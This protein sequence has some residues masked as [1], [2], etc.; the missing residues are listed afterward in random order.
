[1]PTSREVLDGN[2][3]RFHCTTSGCTYSNRD[4]CG[5]VL[6]MRTHF[7]YETAE[8][9]M[10]NATFIFK[11]GI[12]QCFNCNRK[13][14]SQL[15]FRE[16][17]RHHILPFP[18]RCHCGTTVASIPDLRRHS[19]SA[20]PKTPLQM[21]FE[22]AEQLLDNIFSEIGPLKRT[23]WFPQRIA[24]DSSSEVEN[25]L[26][27]N[28]AN[29]CSSVLN[30][31]N[32]TDIEMAE[33]A[34]SRISVLKA[35]AEPRQKENCCKTPSTN[36]SKSIE[37]PSSTSASV[38]EFS[39]EYN[40]INA[41]SY[42]TT[43]KEPD[44]SGFCV[45]NVPDYGIDESRID[46]IKDI[47]Q[48]NLN[49][50][51]S[52]PIKWQ[53]LPQSKPVS[54]V[55]SFKSSLTVRKN[56]DSRNRKRNNTPSNSSCLLISKD[57]GE[58][59]V[60]SVPQNVDSRHTARD[61]TPSISS[62]SLI[63]KDN[64]QMLGE[65][66]SEL[67]TVFSRVTE[68]DSEVLPSRTESELDLPPV[69]E[70]AP[71][72]GPGKFV[73]CDEKFK[74]LACLSWETASEQLFKNHVWQHFHGISK[75]CNNIDCQSTDCPLV[76]GMAMLVKSNVLSMDTSEYPLSSTPTLQLSDSNID[77][78]ISSN[79]SA[80]ESLREVEIS[81]PTDKSKMN[82]TTKAGNLIQNLTLRSAEKL[83][84]S[85]PT[86]DSLRSK[87]C[88]HLHF[89]SEL[90]D[91]SR[92]YENLEKNDRENVLGNCVDDTESTHMESDAPD[93]ICAPVSGEDSI[94][95][96]RRK[97]MLSVKPDANQPVEYCRYPRDSTPLSTACDQCSYT[98]NCSVQLRWHVDSCHPEFAVKKKKEFCCTE[99]GFSD[100]SKD[101]LIW[102]MAHHIGE[103]TF[104][105]FACKYC[106]KQSTY[107]CRVMKHV[108]HSHSCKAMGFR[109]ESTNIA[110]MDGIFK[111]PFCSAGYPWGSLFFRHIELQHKLKKL[112]EYLAHAYHK[113]CCPEVI[114]FPKHLIS[115]SVMSE[116][117][118]DNQSLMDKNTSYGTATPYCTEV[119]NVS[120]VLL[121][122]EN[123][124]ES[125][126]NKNYTET[127]DRAHNDHV[128][129]PDA[130][131]NSECTDA[132]FSSA[133][134]VVHK[135]SGDVGKY[136][137]RYFQKSDTEMNSE[138][139]VKN[140]D[141][142][143]GN[144][145]HV[146][147]RPNLTKPAEKD[148]IYNSTKRK[149]KKYVSPKGNKRSFLI[150]PACVPTLPRNVG[151]N[152]AS[153]FEKSLPN[154]FIFSQP[155]KCPKCY[156]TDR[157]RLNLI[158]H[159]NGHLSDA[160]KGGETSVASN[161]QANKGDGLSFD[162]WNP[163]K[164]HVEMPESNRLVTNKRK[165][166]TIVSEEKKKEHVQRA[167]KKGKSKRGKRDIKR[168]RLTDEV[169]NCN[170]IES[171]TT[172]LCMDETANSGSVISI[173]D[174]ISVHSLTSN[175]DT[176]TTSTPVSSTPAFGQFLQNHANKIVSTM[177]RCESCS[178]T[179]TSETEYEK[180]AKDA[181]SSTYYV[182]R[183][184]GTMIRSLSNVHLHFKENHPGS[185]VLVDEWVSTNK[186]SKQR[187]RPFSEVSDVGL[188]AKKPKMSITDGKI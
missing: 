64:G 95:P 143:K 178:S 165:N 24:H 140:L 54:K 41:F 44:S 169:A 56:V 35:N 9:E 31:S 123:P 179:F 132:G 156:Y 101:T 146:T 3:S 152:A 126:L 98:C 28:E 144:I 15:S 71:P 174:S 182:C 128:S 175:S 134:S 162:L 157:I 139:L 171:Q 76:L 151:N 14:N 114:E 36:V 108:R 21:H 43:I 38:L 16:H 155:I 60:E 142:P 170:T 163:K 113:K 27:T 121:P 69:D 160:S 50:P 42:S 61:N 125:S 100:N 72:S 25:L 33:T 90:G 92:K 77:S 180:H 149:G 75:I 4:A 23:F 7:V 102:H 2:V 154:E 97:Q 188:P 63:S 65:S 109:H 93:N 19:N 86:L 48:G 66:E 83:R 17:V 47:V 10:P 127:D 52:L 167:S 62:C 185:L 13:T 85:A 59:Q 91:L 130:Q 145:F 29:V 12:F 107:M 46:S 55:K 53:W 116:I 161:I 150:S 177:H 22:D 133:Q 30:E 138:K 49:K 129:Q 115:E 131:R 112:A 67:L 18:Y 70:P 148:I 158:R 118:K 88:R 106:S 111:C 84:F 119:E 103:H 135:R 104:K 137:R 166:Q 124:T 34:A 58:M 136:K 172:S 78:D 1:M 51:E 20:H 39:T 87:A 164:L 96:R 37:D 80:L 147:L 181:H 117:S 153:D 5:I 81:S 74:C 184:C 110:Y 8:R 79:R 168:A 105:I 82:S 89:N 40:Y 94:S 57:N 183:S 187:V 11:D 6:H 73:F 120:K 122:G 32:V 26:D 45:L 159:Y 68:P 173:D 186:E 141:Q 99:C 176:R